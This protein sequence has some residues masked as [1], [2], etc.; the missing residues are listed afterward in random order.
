MDGLKVT[1]IEELRNQASGSLVE[2][3]PF[4]EGT[5]F[6]ARLRRPSMLSLVRAKKIPNQLLTSANKLFMTGPS[7]FSSS[8]ERMMDDIFA[9]MDVICDAAMVE[10]TYSEL[11]EAGIELTDEQLMFIFGY[12]QNGV[13]QL[14]SF[15][16]E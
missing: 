3:P 16:T 15:R 12:T 4:A 6:V 13:K 14:D 7:G 8:D 1:S 9:V 11:R 5:Q 2:L 10:P